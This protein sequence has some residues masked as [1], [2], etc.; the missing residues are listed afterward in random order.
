MYSVA[1]AFLAYPNQCSVLAMWVSA[2]LHTGVQFFYDNYNPKLYVP[3]LIYLEKHSCPVPNILSRHI[4]LFLIAAIIPIWASMTSAFSPLE[5]LPPYVALL[6]L[7]GQAYVA[8]L[9]LAAGIIHK[10]QK[11]A[12]RRPPPYDEENNHSGTE[13]E[14]CD[15]LQR[16]DTGVH[17]GQQTDAPSQLSRRNSHSSRNTNATLP[18][19]SVF[20]VGDD[21][22]DASSARS[23]VAADPPHR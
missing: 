5:I 22:S 1:T 4:I 11:L 18:N 8:L 20:E 15:P 14:D 23:D 7:A 17:T 6:A 19:P 2:A 13:L 16:Q 3:C 21:S 12:A 10:L 9:D